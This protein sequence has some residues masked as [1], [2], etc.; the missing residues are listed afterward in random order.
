MTT[1][2]LRGRQF[3]SPPTFRPALGQDIEDIFNVDALRDEILDLLDRVPSNLQ[4]AYRAE[5]DECERQIREGGVTGLYTGGK[6]LYDLV[7]EMRGS[8]R[9]DEEPPPPGVPRPVEPGFPWLPVAIVGIAGLGAL[10]F[11]TRR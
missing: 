4:G 8:L 3:F 2:A 1:Q 11:L 9:P 10:Y 6:C 5:F 7:R